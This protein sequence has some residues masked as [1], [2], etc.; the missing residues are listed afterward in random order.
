[1]KYSTNIDENNL[2]TTVQK[3]S[4]KYSKVTSIDKKTY[5]SISYL[6]LNLWVFLFSFVWQTGL[7]SS[8][9]LSK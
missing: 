6:F 1:M 4:D 9:T 2:N 7:W 3:Y 5:W 8:L